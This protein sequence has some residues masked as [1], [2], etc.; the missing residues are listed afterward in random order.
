[1]CSSL[2]PSL[3]LA[4]STSRFMASGSCCAGSPSRLSSPSTT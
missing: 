1:M 4:K 3:A 2:M